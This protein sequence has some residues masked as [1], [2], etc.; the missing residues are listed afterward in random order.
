MKGFVFRTKG[1]AS[2][3][4]PFLIVIAVQVHVY[5]ESGTVPT[6]EDCISKIQVVLITYFVD[7]VIIARQCLI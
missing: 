2:V 4:L 5:I 6:W 1:L 3:F 7:S